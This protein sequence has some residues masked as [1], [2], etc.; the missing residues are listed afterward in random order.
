MANQTIVFDPSAGVPV[1][2]NLTIY[3]G[4]KFSATFNV[5]T[6][7]SASY[8]LTGFTASSQ[9][10]KSVAIGATLGIQTTFTAGITSAADGVLNISLGST[11][12]RG[13]KAGRYMYNVLVD[14]GSTVYSL[15]DGNIMVYA[16]L[17]SAP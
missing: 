9:M 13:L 2:A 7:G 16:G 10:V 15:I 14:S 4:S 3:G 1:G 5:Q 6:T 8:D 12:T 17:S 11:D